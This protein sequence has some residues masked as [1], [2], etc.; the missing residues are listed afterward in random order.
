MQSN[1]RGL[2]TLKNL[3]IPKG[4]TIINWGR[5]YHNKPKLHT[6]HTNKPK[7]TICAYYRHA[8]AAYPNTNNGLY[9]CHTLL[10]HT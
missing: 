10:F 9:Q 7:T 2:H 4:I 5:L 6:F 3:E 1:H 8:H